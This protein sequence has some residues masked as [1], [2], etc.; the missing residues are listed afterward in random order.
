MYDYEWLTAVNKPSPWH[1]AGDQDRITAV[2]VESGVTYIGRC[3]FD[4][5]RNLTRVYFSRTKA[6]WDAISMGTNV[7]P[8]GV[9][10]VFSASG[11][12][13]TG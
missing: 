3:A 4:T 5:C 12:P 10:I 9:E 7:F 2:Q 1:D 8:E 6:Q 13:I 11:S